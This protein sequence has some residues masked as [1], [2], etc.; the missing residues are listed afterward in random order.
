MS[1]DVLEQAIEETR[2]HLDG[3]ESRRLIA[4]AFVTIV[5]FLIPIVL[6]FSALI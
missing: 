5:L 2:A 6:F 4:W 3:R 1:I